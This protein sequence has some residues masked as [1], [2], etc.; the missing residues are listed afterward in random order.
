M[1]NENEWTVERHLLGQPAA[2]VELYHR[3]VAL[4]EEIG[5]F[6]YAVSKSSITFKGTQRGFAG[7]KPV[8]NGLRGYFDAR[9]RWSDPRISS[10]APFSRTLF[11]HH[12]RLAS[13]DDLDAGVSDW[14]REAYAVGAGA[15][16]DG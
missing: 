15:H 3:F 4:L 12:F 14:L 13:L 2:S 5:P 11:V 10:A 8:R 1:D 9:E 16:L 6:S 7:A